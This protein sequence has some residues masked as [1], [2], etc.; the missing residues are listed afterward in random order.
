MMML[1]V[2]SRLTLSYR[3]FLCRTLT[4][5][6]RRP[7]ILRGQKGASGGLPHPLFA[8]L[9][10]SYASIECFAVQLGKFKR[11]QILND[12]MEYRPGSGAGGPPSPFGSVNLR[13][14]SASSLILLGCGE[15]R[16]QTQMDLKKSSGRFLNNEFLKPFP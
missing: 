8:T 10:V 12:V 14:G 1:D 15:L 7:L 13:S 6:P 3:S 11:K 4:V 2:S 5:S 16:R 9:V